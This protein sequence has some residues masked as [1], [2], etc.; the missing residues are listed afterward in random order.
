MKR[1]IILLLT[2]LALVWVFWGNDSRQPASAPLQVEKKES[3]AVLPVSQALMPATEA[4][5]QQ[6][7]SRGEV[8]VGA[9][10]D[11]AALPAVA[12]RS[13]F[14][15]AKL[16]SRVES[17]PDEAGRVKVIKTLETN[18]KQRF[19]RLEETYVEGK[20]VL[21]NL[22]EQ[23]AMVA[24]QLLTQKPAAMAEERFVQL[25]GETGADEVRKVGDSFLVTYHAEPDNPLA[26]DAY[27]SR[28]KSA[29]EGLVV[30]PN[31]IR[32]LF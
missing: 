10:P 9:L 2:A 28:M 21:Q 31:Y 24:N 13:I 15:H 23:T 3:A 4:P 29:V 25:L 5:V 14:S 17:E 11:A 12:P 7:S 22:V 26:L 32:R 19:V 16:I 1:K 30:E 27:I 6:E 18:M 20:A 8:A